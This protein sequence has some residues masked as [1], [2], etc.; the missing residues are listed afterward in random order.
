MDNVSK[1]AYLLELFLSI[2]NIYPIYKKIYDLLSSNKY[3]NDMALDKI[4]DA[5]EQ[6]GEENEKNIAVKVQIRKKQIQEKEKG[7]EN[8]VNSALSK[9]EQSFMW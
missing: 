2:K 9:I 1:K 7:E 4:Y 3:L 8:E 6:I 5:V